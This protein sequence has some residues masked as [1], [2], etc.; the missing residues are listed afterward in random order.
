MTGELAKAVSYGEF[1]LLCGTNYVERVEE[2]I[3]T[4]NELSHRNRKS[5]PFLRNKRII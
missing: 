2:L 4:G 3:K 1:V 5:P